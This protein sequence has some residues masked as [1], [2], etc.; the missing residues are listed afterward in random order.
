MTEEL[1]LREFS[2]TVYDDAEWW[3]DVPWQCS[4]WRKLNSK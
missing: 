3:H 2:E 1:S 4:T